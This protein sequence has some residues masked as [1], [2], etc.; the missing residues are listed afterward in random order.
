MKNTDRNNGEIGQTNEVT[1]DNLDKLV[2]D[3]V[4]LLLIKGVTIATA[5][6]CTGGLL[7]EP[8]SYTHL[9]RQVSIGS[10][11]ITVPAPTITAEYLSRLFCTFSLALSPVIHLDSPL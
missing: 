8:V 6:S 3:V 9:S 2:T 4:K 10:S 11:A 1:P 5:E 7:S